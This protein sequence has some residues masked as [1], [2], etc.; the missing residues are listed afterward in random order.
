MSTLEIISIMNSSKSGDRPPSPDKSNGS[1]KAKEKRRDDDLY[2]KTTSLVAKAKEGDQEAV[3]ALYRLYE[4]R[5][6]KAVKK[7]LGS[8]L[9]GRLETMDL[10]QSVRKDVLLD[11]KAFD[12]RGPDSFFHWL[13]T[14]I[15]RK[16]QDKGR[17]FS[18]GKRDLDKEQRIHTGGVLPG[19][20]EAGGPSPSQ[21]AIADEHLERLMRLLDKLPELQRKALV[22]RMRDEMEF[23]EIGKRMGKSPEAVRKLYSRAMKRIGDL[24]YKEKKDG[25]Q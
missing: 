16:I 7:K 24:M 10:V 18:A 8:K 6:K 25:A 9:R 15:I 22:L 13:L 3:S 4:F 21:A 20:H 2:A 5:L 23:D 19:E 11:V 1:S 14:C 17:Y 12:Y